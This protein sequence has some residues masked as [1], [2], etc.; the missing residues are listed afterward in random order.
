MN[1]V[2]T[3]TQFELRAPLMAER[4]WQPATAPAR[5]VN[6][7]MHY[8]VDHARALGVPAPVS[9]VTADY[10]DKVDRMGLID[11]ELAVI[12]EALEAENRSPD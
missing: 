8:I 1:S 6:K 11:E 12:F 5:L 10:Y 4:K 7:D 2:A 3:S 9:R